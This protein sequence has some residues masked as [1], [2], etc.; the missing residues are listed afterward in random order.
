MNVAYRTY[1]VIE[2]NSRGYIFE[3]TKKNIRPKDVLWNLNSIT[4][5]SDWPEKK[6]C[7]LFG[8]SGLRNDKWE[9]CRWLCLCL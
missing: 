8:P 9:K 6:L 3:Y 5:S 4:F 2:S 7:S 1:K